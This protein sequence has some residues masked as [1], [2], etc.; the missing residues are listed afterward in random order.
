MRR[1]TDFYIIDLLKFL[2]LLE[3]RNK[4]MILDI[5][6]K[7]Y[8]TNTSPTT[9]T[10][11]VMIAKQLYLFRE[12]PF[13]LWKWGDRKKLKFYIKQLIGWCEC[14]IEPDSCLT[15]FALYVCY[16]NNMED[17]LDFFEHNT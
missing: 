12:P 8:A 9:S 13:C 7:R 17:T 6:K 5:D 15:I 16:Y 10:L 1:G 14:G 2:S 3:I 4:L 11:R